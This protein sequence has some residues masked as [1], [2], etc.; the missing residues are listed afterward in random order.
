MDWD[1]D[2]DLPPETP[3]EIY[4]NLRRSLQRQ[5]GFELHFVVC[6]RSK[7]TE[8]F[9]RLRREIPEK[10][11]AELVL[12]R[13]DTTLLDKVKELAATTQFDVLFVRDLDATLLDYED[14]KR[15]A[16]W[17]EVQIYEVD[18]RGVPPILQHLNWARETLR[19][20]FPCAFVIGC[21]PTTIQ[22]LSERA[23]DF[24]DWRLGVYRFPPEPSDID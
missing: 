8:I 15:Q 5:T 7:E 24:F 10:R 23:P 6:D 3:E 16:G 1:D 14:T 2:E 4:G 13:K 21:R 22:Y 9:D 17:S 12:D 18:W 11:F 20:R 19:D